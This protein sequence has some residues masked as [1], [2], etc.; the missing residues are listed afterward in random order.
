[1]DSLWKS[2][3]LVLA[4]PRVDSAKKL[5]SGDI[6]VI[7]TD[8]ETVKVIKNISGKDGLEVLEEGNKKPKVKIKNI[9]SEYSAE[10]I[11]NSIIEQNQNLEIESMNDVKPV[12]KCG[13]RNRDVVDWMMEVSPTIYNAILNKCTF[14]GLMSNFPRPYVTAS[15]CRRCLALDHITK[16]CTNDLT[17]HHCAEAGHESSKCQRK[18]EEP[19]CSHCGDRHRTM[20]KDCRIWAQR[21]QITDRNLHPPSYE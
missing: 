19:V 2:I 7:S 9:P 18:N 11:T 21:I 20:S 10:F 17:C 16:N 12:Y 6:L 4:N 3:K 8:T 1:M 13:P 15:H 14:I 5:P